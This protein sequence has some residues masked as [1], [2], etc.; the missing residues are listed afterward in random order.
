MVYCPLIPVYCPLIPYSCLR[1]IQISNWRYVVGRLK[2]A[3]IDYM[4]VIARGGAYENVSDIDYWPPGADAGAFMTSILSGRL[5]IVTF[6]F[7]ENPDLSLTLNSTRSSLYRAAYSMMDNPGFATKDNYEI[8][9][10]IHRAG[11]K[12]KEREKV[13]IDQSVVANAL[14]DSYVVQ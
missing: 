12:P 7:N 8:F 13:F 2:R 5:S 11:A 10:L 6:L 14:G 3:D 4:H 9:R 1:L